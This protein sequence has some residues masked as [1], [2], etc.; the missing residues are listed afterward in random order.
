M[1]LNDMI[2]LTKGKN[3]NK[4]IDLKTKKWNKY[5]EFEP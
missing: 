3:R 5:P 1:K 2:R 4:N